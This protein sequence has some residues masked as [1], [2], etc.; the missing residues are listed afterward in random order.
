MYLQLGGDEFG[1]GSYR[2]IGFGFKSLT[3]VNVPAYI[4]YIERANANNTKGDLVF[5]TRDVETDTQPT[6]RVVITAA[7]LVGVGVTP[8]V[9]LHVGMDDAVTA[10]VTDVL[11]INHSST[12]TPAANF[13]TGLHFTGESS[14]TDARDMARIQSIWTTATDASRASALLFQTLTGA[15]ALATQVTIYGDGNTGFGV[16]LP[17]AV[18]HLKAGTTAASTAPLKLTSGIV[19]TVAEAGAIEFTT[20]DF[21]ATITTGAARKAFVLDDGTR[22]TS[23]RVPFATTNGRLID[24]SDMTFSVD[25]LTVTKLSAGNV[26][27]SLFDHFADS[28][29]GGAEADIYSDTL[30]ASQLATNGDKIIASYGGNFVTVGTESVD[31]FV[32]FG[33]TQIYD[34]TG[35]AP[36]SGTTSWRIYVEIIRVSASVVRYTVSLNTTGASGFVYAKS[37]ELT[38]LTLSNTNILKITGSS[39]GVGSGAGDIV[40]KMSYVRW[41]PVA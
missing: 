29:V 6:E 27:K 16:T 12:G 3:T 19:M 26:A 17:T 8:S 40:G 11:R 31:L 18:V 20:D 33:G 28:T 37:G 14:T 41:V 34:S 9:R 13:G 4:G 38:G 22:L 2:A 24:D 39:S 25:T 7:G 30:A 36:T 10:A 21:F 1:T 35:I 15:G 23:G 5:A 32:Y